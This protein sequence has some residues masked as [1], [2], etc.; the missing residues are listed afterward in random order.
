LFAGAGAG[1]GAGAILIPGNLKIQ[2]LAQLKHWVQVSTQ[3]WAQDIS[4]ETVQGVA[5]L[6]WFDITKLGHFLL[7]A[8]LAWLLVRAWP[9]RDWRVVLLDLLLLAAASELLQLFAVGRSPLFSDWLIDAG[10]IVL[11][12][13]LSGKVLKSSMKDV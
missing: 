1:A 10:G 2:L 4:S 8:S 11:G 12:L 13:C 7:F 6:P 3:F 5:V 9:E